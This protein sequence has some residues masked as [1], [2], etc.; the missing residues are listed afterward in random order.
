MH[1]YQRIHIGAWRSNRYYLKK[2]SPL[3]YF[4]LP[5]S[6]A[7]SD[8]GILFQKNGMIIEIWYFIK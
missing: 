8:R 4:A 5:L 7:C 1:K 3:P 6:T 2:K